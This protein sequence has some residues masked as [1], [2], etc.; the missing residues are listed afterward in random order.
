MYGLLD[1]ATSGMVAQRQRLD[2]ISSNLANQDAILDSKGEVNPY[3]RRIPVFQVGAA[4]GAGSAGGRNY[5]VRMAKI[6]LDNA[7]P[8]LGAFDPSNPLAYKTGPNKGYVA[9]SSISS[10]VENINAME[11]MRAYEANVMAADISKQMVASA[12]RLIA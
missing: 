9:R 2:V 5:G 7:P 3:R 12:L 8:A 4:S 10:V 1:I 6:E 11:A